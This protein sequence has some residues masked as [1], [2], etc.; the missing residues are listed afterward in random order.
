MEALTLYFKEGQGVWCTVISRPRS[1]KGTIKLSLI[2]G[3]DRETPAICIYSTCIA[4][5]SGFYVYLPAK[6]ITG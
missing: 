4:L 2:G 1:E 3:W 6:H 5:K